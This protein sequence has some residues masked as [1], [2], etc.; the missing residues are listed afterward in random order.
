MPFSQNAFQQNAF[1]VATAAPPPV[2]NRNLL[3]M[4]VGQMFFVGAFLVMFVKALR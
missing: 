3:L 2:T 1:Q 4:G